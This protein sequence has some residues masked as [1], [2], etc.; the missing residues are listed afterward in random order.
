MPTKTSSF[1]DWQPL[2]LPSMVWTSLVGQVA[3]AG[4]VAD[5]GGAWADDQLDAEANADVFGGAIPKPT[6]AR[7][8]YGA[9]IGFG[10]QIPIPDY[11][12]AKQPTGRLT[13]WS[14]QLGDDYGAD[15]GRRVAFQLEVILTSLVSGVV[16]SDLT[17]A[18]GS[19]KF[20]GYGALDSANDNAE[21]QDTPV[22]GTL[23]LT[24]AVFADMD[25]PSDTGSNN[26]A[27]TFGPDGVCRLQFLV[28]IP[29]TVAIGDVLEALF[30][31][32]IPVTGASP[33]DVAVQFYG[34]H[35][36]FITPYFP[37]LA[38]SGEQMLGAVEGELEPQP[39]SDILPY[40]P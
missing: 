24:N 8:G 14:G 17:S 26:D 32:T 7:T 3:A 27:P 28:E 6:F 40:A 2:H 34:A 22:A 25:L 9:D 35:Y 21:T 12:I 23:T 16:G 13:E 10:F 19:V 30:K 11:V 33:A 1:A 18:A 20:R 37:I 15:G 36:R 4:D 39:R 38:N 29:N 5:A 31:V